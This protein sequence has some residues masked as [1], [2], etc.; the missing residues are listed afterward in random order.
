MEN[1]NKLIPGN[2]GITFAGAGAAVGT[3]LA[4][5]AG[6]ALAA[7]AAIGLGVGF[8]VWRIKKL[9]SDDQK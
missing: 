9:V 8:L 3:G 6:T 7:P 1:K 4:A 5:I 2:S